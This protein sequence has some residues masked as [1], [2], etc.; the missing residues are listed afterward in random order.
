MSYFEK[1]LIANDEDQFNSQK[2]KSDANMPGKNISIY[3]F[4]RVTN[5]NMGHV[6]CF[7]YMIRL[8]KDEK[9]EET[10][11]MHYDNSDNVNLDTFNYIMNIAKRNQCY[12]YYNG[13]IN[14]DKLMNAFATPITLCGFNSEIMI[15]ISLLTF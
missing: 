4:E 10:T 15:Y 6:P 7:N 1:T 5:K 12:H 9:N 3:D 14:N 13:K 11:F 2:V 8:C